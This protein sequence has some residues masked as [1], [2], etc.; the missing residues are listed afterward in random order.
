MACLL[1]FLSNKKLIL[2]L[3]FEPLQQF[4]IENKYSKLY[5]IFIKFIFLLMYMYA[6]LVS[7]SSNQIKNFI[8]NKY[9]IKR[10]NVI[11]Y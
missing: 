7:V 8:V 3:G 11:I 1:K 2:R 9:K 5:M 10:S 4:E 6:D